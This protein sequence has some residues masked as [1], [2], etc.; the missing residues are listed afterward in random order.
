VDLDYKGL[1]NAGTW[2]IGRLQTEREEERAQG[3]ALLLAGD[4]LQRARPLFATDVEGGWQQIELR[5]EGQQLREGG[6]HCCQESPARLA[7]ESVGDVQLEQHVVGV[8]AQ[9]VAGGV[10]D[11]RA[12]SARVDT[13]LEG[14]KVGAGRVAK[15]VGSGLSS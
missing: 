8:A 13:P 5:R 10:G 15:L 11:G 2:F 9:V 6:S 7:V 14:L 12:A 1:G 4:R 3:V